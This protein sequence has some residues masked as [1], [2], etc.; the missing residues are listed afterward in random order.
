MA[1]QLKLRVPLS[2]R[3]TLDN[4]SL[5]R[6][7]DPIIDRLLQCDSS[8]SRQGLLEGKQ[9]EVKGREPEAESVCR[10]LALVGLAGSG[11]TL[12]S[13]YIW[14]RCMERWTNAE[15]KAETQLSIR[16][17]IHISLSDFKTTIVGQQDLMDAFFQR[18]APWF[19][20]SAFCDM[21]DKLQLLVVMDGLDEVSNEVM[22]VFRD[23]GLDKW[24]KCRFVLT[25]R[26][27]HLVDIRQ[28][29]PV[30]TTEGQGE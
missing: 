4:Q 6:D 5:Q 27:E 26:Q 9:L 16:L 7:L 1:Q 20:T 11:K 23:N 29:A 28:V 25:S 14:Q 22:N 10:M 8:W 24:A 2:V 21:R 30:K 18:H 3:Q 17:P 15:A 12:T 19:L 13:W